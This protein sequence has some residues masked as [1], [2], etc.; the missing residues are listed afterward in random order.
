MI[1]SRTNTSQQ[2]FDA[3]SLTADIVIL[4]GSTRQMFYTT[5]KTFEDDRKWVPCILGGKVYVND[6]SNVMTGFVTLTDIEWYTQMPIEGDYQ[7]GRISNPAQSVLDDVDT[8]DPETG[9]LTHEAAWRSVDY[10]ISDGSNSAWCV[11]VPNLCLIV[12]KN[13]THLTAMPLYAVLKFVDTRTG[14]TMRILKSIDFT[15]ESYNTER[16]VM[17]GDSGDEVLLDPLSFTDTIPSGQTILD[18]PWLRSVN[19]Q[20]MGVDGEVPDNEA[21]YL[22]VKEDGTTASG[23]RQFT[24]DEIENLQLTGVK[25]KTL[26]F[27]ARMIQSKFKVRCYGK[28]KESTDAW[29]NPLSDNNPFYTVQFTMTLND[30]LHADPVQLTGNKQDVNMSIPASYEMKLRY[31][32]KDVPENRRCLFR[33]HWKAQD[34]KTGAIISLGT[35]PN[36]SFVPNAKG[37]SFPEGFDVW[38]DVSLYSG[39]DIVVVGNDQVIENNQRVISP[40]FE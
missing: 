32:G 31:N 5:E 6:P 29:Q 30:T 11:N 10:L 3:L 19:T 26:T 24:E 23:W 40:S 37:F 12:H 22:W 39:C 15:T 9:E 27:D 21:S 2:T 16:A 17:K 25:T 34:L 20:L 36:I 28:R 13:V 38:A 33:I 8:Y 4:G 7:T 1:K 14:L 18:I 35:S